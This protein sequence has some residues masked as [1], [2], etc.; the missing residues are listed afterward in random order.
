MAVMQKKLQIDPHNSFRCSEKSGKER[1]SGVC[2]IPVNLEAR[3]EIR[4]GID[5]SSMVEFTCN[6]THKVTITK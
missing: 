6:H 1:C 3:A 4:N 2:L 5:Y